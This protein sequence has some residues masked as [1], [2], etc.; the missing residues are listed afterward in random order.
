[1]SALSAFPSGMRRR[2]EETTGCCPSGCG[3]GDARGD[4]GALRRG[5]QRGTDRGCENSALPNRMSQFSRPCGSPSSRSL[6]APRG[7]RDGAPLRDRAA[8]ARSPELSAARATRRPPTRL[9]SP[10]PPGEPGT[11]SPQKWTSASLTYAS[12]RISGRDDA[13]ARRIFAALLSAIGDAEI[14][15]GQDDMIDEVLATDVAA[16]A[17]QYAVSAYMLSVPTDRAAAVRSAM[18]EMSIIGDF[19]EALQELERAA[20]RPLVPPGGSLARFFCPS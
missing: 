7:E 12:R 18:D 17:A 1:M 3:D 11:P 9:P 5:A 16:C 20:V 19:W 14:D 15:L 8:R 13:T 6:A 10:R 2:N 4:G